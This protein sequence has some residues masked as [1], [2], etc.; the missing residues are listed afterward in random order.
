M[1]RKRIFWG[2]LIVVVAGLVLQTSWVR[3]PWYGGRSLSYW[4]EAIV[5]NDRPARARKAVTA[6][7]HMGSNAVPYL[8]PR[9]YDYQRET[10]LRSRIRSYINDRFRGKVYIDSKFS[11]TE[12]AEAALDALGPEAWPA[13]PVLEWLMN[14][15]P[16]NPSAPY[17]VARIGP[18]G[19]PTLKRGLT[20][21]SNAIKWESEICLA[22]LKEHS[23]FVFP[24]FDDV[25]NRYFQRRCELNMK[26]LGMAWE[27]YR[28]QHPELGTNDVLVPSAVGQ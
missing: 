4:L 15:N 14:T 19:V 3:E 8:I 23:K 17:L 1:K 11:P 22:A 27:K 7:Q 13:L 25:E 10:P 24:D 28:A 21:E 26:V 9:L 18:Q 5:D 20:N 2:L 16:P 12:K 6:I